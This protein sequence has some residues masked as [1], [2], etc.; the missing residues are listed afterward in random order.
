MFGSSAIEYICFGGNGFMIFFLIFITTLFFVAGIRDMKRRLYILQQLGQLISPKKQ[1]YYKSKKLLPTINFL[2]QVSLHSWIDLRKL[3]IDYGKKYFYRHEIFMP[4]AF[5]LA[6]ACLMVAFFMLVDKVPFST[7]EEVDQERKKMIIAS[8]SMSLYFFLQFFW[9]LYSASYINEEFV[10]HREILKLNKDLLQDILMFKE[11]YFADKL[12]PH[13]IK[14]GA[15]PEFEEGSSTGQVVNLKVD[16]SSVKDGEDEHKKG[17]S[18]QEARKI[19]GLTQK[20][21]SSVKSNQVYDINHWNNKFS[22]Q[23]SL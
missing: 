4:V 10:R 22:S 21:A 5:Y 20:Y 14:T 16:E 15:E 6:V 3:A 12:N 17:D 13:L 1:Q 2:D 23:L 8:V 11:F 18:E 19:G 9:L 7:A